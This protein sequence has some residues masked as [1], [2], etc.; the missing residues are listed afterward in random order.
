VVGVGP[1]GSNFVEGIGKIGVE[2]AIDDVVGGSIEV[3]GN[4]GGGSGEGGFLIEDAEGV[5]KLDLTEAA[6]LAVFLPAIAAKKAEVGGGWLEVDVEKLEIAAVG[7]LDG[8]KLA[9]VFGDF[10]LI[11]DAAADDDG[12]ALE[13]VEAVVA[14]AVEEFIDELFEVVGVGDFLKKNDVGLEAADGI[15]GVGLA[16]TV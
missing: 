7:H 4:D 5:G 16:G 2:E 3:A 8:E 14:I 9:P 12:A 11:V 15:G 1:A 6:I 10:N 13:V